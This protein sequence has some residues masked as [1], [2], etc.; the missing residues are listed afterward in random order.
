[1][2]DSTQG[3]QEIESALSQP[4]TAP[5]DGRQR[6]AGTPRELTSVRHRDWLPAHAWHRQATARLAPIA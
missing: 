3:R 4:L 2:V 5:N 1:M 6:L